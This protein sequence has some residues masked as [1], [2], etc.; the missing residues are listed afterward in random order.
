MKLTSEQGDDR[1]TEQLSLLELR[2]PCDTGDKQGWGGAEEG[3]ATVF[4]EE[5][6]HFSILALLALTAV[7]MAMTY[8]LELLFFLCV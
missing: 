4:L 2:S 6:P 5:L 7:Q 1:G 3:L 8:Y